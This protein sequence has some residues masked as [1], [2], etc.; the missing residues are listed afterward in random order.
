MCP[1]CATAARCNP[2]RT[3][4]VQDC[5][6]ELEA[7]GLTAPE[8]ANYIIGADG[9]D[10]LLPT[11]GN[12]VICG[13]DGNDQIPQFG[14]PSTT[15]D[16]QTGDIFLGGAGDDSVFSVGR[17]TFIGGDGSDYAGNTYYGSTFNGG[18]GND[19]VGILFDGT[20]NGGDGD[21]FVDDLYYGTFNG[22]GG[23]DRLGRN[24]RGGTFVPGDETGC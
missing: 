19:G 14:R 18:S 16:L 5:L 21:D 2:S 7:A 6:Q 23:C 9:D 11:G 17:G 15:T 10:I 24:I 20:F 8:N 12:D 22:D 3:K 13:F 4:T 1:T